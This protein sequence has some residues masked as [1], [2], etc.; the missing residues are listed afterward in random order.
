MV[1]YSSVV[2]IGVVT[3]GALSFSELGYFSAC[4]ILVGHSL[5]SPLL[6]VLASELYR[7]T[8]SRSFIFG[9]TSS[10]TST[11]LLVLSLCIGLNFGLPPFLNFWVE[12]ALF[13][14]MG[15]S[16]ILSLIPLI[17][18]SFFS[19]IFC[20]FFYIQRIGGPKSCSITLSSPAY[21]FV[22]PITFSLFFIF[23]LSIFQP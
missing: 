10:S 20:I 4:G 3:L 2:H 12:V 5:L 19:F 8:G 1:A 21:I 16:W 17:L 13:S 15:S 11:L 14:T 22:A 9:F 18:S 6:F 7:F 23:G